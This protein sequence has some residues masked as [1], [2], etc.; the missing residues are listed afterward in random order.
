VEQGMNKSRIAKTAA[1]LGAALLVALGGQ[2]RSQEQVVFKYVAGTE[3]MAKGC[4]GKLEV[5]ASDL[6]F[7]CAQLSLT[8]PYPSI[9]QM[10][11]QPQV[12]K[13]IRK[14]KLAWAIKPTSAH[15]KHQGFFSVLYTEKGHTHAIILKTRD[16]TMRPYMAEIDLKTGLPIESRQD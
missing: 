7:E 8:I 1:I 9:T 12:S 15:S 11:F 16:E 13:K 5:G 2:A 14:M 10:E 6:I 3:S 4:K